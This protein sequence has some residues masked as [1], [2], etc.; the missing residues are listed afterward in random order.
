MA[1]D[2]ST[3]A[4]EIVLRTPDELKALGHPLRS[5]LLDTLEQTPLS[6]KGLAERLG[7]THGKIGHH[8]KVLERAG[9]IHVVETRQVRALT[10]KVFA[11]AYD[12]IRVDMGGGAR[13][14]QFFF[15][16]VVGQIADGDQPLISE[17]RFYTALVPPATAH[18]F[19]TRLAQL[20]DE[21]AAAAGAGAEPDPGSGE[22]LPTALAC[23]MFRAES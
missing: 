17:R 10:E 22:L 4:R 6:A 7:M 21:F 15:Q 14:L 1:P 20:A 8:L 12:R 11:P 13:E 18:E 2:R 9:L 19:A 3:T 23:A 5:R 16:Q